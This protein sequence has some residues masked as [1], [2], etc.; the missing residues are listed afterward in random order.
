[1]M[2]DQTV[3][4]QHKYEFLHLFQTAVSCELNTIISGDGIR[5]V[6]TSKSLFHAHVTFSFEAIFQ[7]KMVHLENHLASSRLLYRGPARLD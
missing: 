6:P 5:K 4:S 7:K 2:I 1:M 3:P